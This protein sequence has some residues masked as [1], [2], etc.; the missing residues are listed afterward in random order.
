MVTK[1]YVDSLFEELEDNIEEF[2]EEH[3]EDYFEEYFEDFEFDNSKE[4]VQ[5]QE[6]KVES[7]SYIIKEFP[8]NTKVLCY[9]NCEVILRSGKAKINSF[10]AADGTEN[11]IQ[12]ITEG[13]DL[14]ENEEMPINHLLLIPRTD[15]RGFTTTTP[16][17]VMIR[18]DYAVVE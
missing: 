8:E 4:D 16:A 17:F 3:F 18:G 5:N 11:G 6:S 7:G 15:T 13:I 2:F 9:A 14:K 12:D 1:S 10:I